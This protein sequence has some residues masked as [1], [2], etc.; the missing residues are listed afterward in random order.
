MGA[1]VVVTATGFILACAAVLA[2]SGS[3]ASPVGRAGTPWLALL[4]TAAVLEALTLASDRL[5][6]LSDLLDV[7]LRPPAARGAAAVVWL[8]LGAWL[9][10]RPTTRTPA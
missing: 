9:V 10:T 2:E 6:A 1:L 5:P 8:L 4:L 7:V 3:A